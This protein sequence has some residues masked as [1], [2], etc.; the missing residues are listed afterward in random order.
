MPPFSKSDLKKYSVPKFWSDKPL[1]LSKAWCDQV[2]RSKSLDHCQADKSSLMLVSPKSWYS[3]PP[4]QWWEVKACGPQSPD[5]HAAWRTPHRATLTCRGL[6]LSQSSQTKRHN[7]STG[8]WM[9][10]VVSVSWDGNEKWRHPRGPFGFCP[11]LSLWCSN[12]STRA[13]LWL[14]W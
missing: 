11:V 2:A 8:A 3:C 5:S 12:Q 13:G 9:G 6:L 4:V 1:S 10:L 14:F 7:T